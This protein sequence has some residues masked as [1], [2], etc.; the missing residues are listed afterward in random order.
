MKMLAENGW[1]LFGAAPCQFPRRSSKKPSA[2]TGLPSELGPSAEGPGLKL[3]F[4][5][6]RRLALVWAGRV[7][8]VWSLVHFPLSRYCG[9]TRQFGVRADRTGSV[10]RGPSS[11][12]HVPLSPSGVGG[13]GP[14]STRPKI[15]SGR[16]VNL[17]VAHSLRMPRVAGCMVCAIGSLLRARGVAS[18]AFPFAL[19][20]P[21]ASG[22]T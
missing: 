16:C 3:A 19:S 22:R 14:A 18:T 4:H 7:S 6:G 13:G 17:C 9:A 21:P 10:L 15:W 11:P 20:A 1:S 5:S 12:A 8:V 2:M